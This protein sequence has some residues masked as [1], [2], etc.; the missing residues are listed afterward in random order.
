MRHIISHHLRPSPSV[1]GG[2]L[3]VSS[4]MHELAIAP[5]ASIYTLMS[6]F[7][8]TRKHWLRSD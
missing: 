1:A 7:Q 5:V 8:D 3:Y 4:Q 2:I 6:S